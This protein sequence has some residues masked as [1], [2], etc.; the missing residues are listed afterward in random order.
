VRGLERLPVT[1]RGGAV[2][3]LC[4]LLPMWY[5]AKA[6]R[7]TVFDIQRAEHRYPAVGEEIRRRLPANAI[8]LSQVQ[9][10]SVRLYG[11]RLTARWDFIEAASRAYKI[12]VVGTGAP[13]RC[14]ARSARR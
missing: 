9:S 8:V 11:E 10:G 2:F 4:V 13:A 1:L 14:R 6:D 7:L 3:L 12:R 5:V